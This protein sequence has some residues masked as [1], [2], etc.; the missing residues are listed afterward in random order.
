M[1]YHAITWCP[2]PATTGEEFPFH[3]SSTSYCTVFFKVALSHIS[4][5]SQHINISCTLR[6]PE[7]VP[8]TFFWYVLIIISFVQWI[9]NLS[10]R[11]RVSAKS[12]CQIHLV[13]TTI[14]YIPHTIIWCLY[15]KNVVPI[16]FCWISSL[17]NFFPFSLFFFF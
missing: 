10:H 7:P 5:L 11:F 2:R 9:K 8:S 4:F 6:N 17:F 15:S 16:Y 3:L 1:R 12:N 13:C 14:Y